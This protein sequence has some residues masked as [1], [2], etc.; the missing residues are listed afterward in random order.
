MINSLNTVFLYFALAVLPGLIWLLFF[1]KR[2]NLPEPKMK[3]L[4]IFYLGMFA[5]IPVAVAEYF[6]L[7]WF[8]EY[9]AFIPLIP[10]LL[11]K[12]ILIIGILEE[13]FKYLV[14][15][16]FVLKN[17][18]LDEPIDLPLYMIISA[19]GFA[20]AEN[21][22]LFAGHNFQMI[23]DT[24][25]LALIRFLGATLL[26][27][28]GSGIIGIFLVMAFYWTRQ[29]LFF[30]ISGFSLSFIVHGMF[31]FFL[32][33]SIIQLTTNNYSIIYPT[34]LLITFYIILSLAIIKIRKL[35]GICIIK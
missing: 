11:I 21:L 20:T 6:G 31:D 30:I 26:H 27:A 12:N 7:K 24:F 22:L 3:V 34:L 13:L 35:K 15:R 23:T 18:C 32:E 1:L 19:L 33:S 14:V 10:Y 17:S 16:G 25:G 9:I 29:R 5:V 28:L 8:D 4:Q 2:D